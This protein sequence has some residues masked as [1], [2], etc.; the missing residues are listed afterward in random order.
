MALIGPMEHLGYTLPERLVPDISHGMMFCKWLR[1]KGYDTD[2]LP[3]YWH[4]YEDGR[5]VQAKAYP[6]T[7]LG[8]W[9][10]HFREEWMPYKAVNYFTG[11]DSL[12]LQYLPRLLPKPAT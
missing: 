9:R 3:K 4:I 1:G 10:Y 7:L 12:A 11:R 8:D 2:A 6:E 5:R